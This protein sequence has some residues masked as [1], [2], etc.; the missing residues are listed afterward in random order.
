MIHNM[1]VRRK[2]KG[3][4]GDADGDDDPDQPE[5]RCHGFIRSL[6]YMV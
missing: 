1:R 2:R 5:V 6:I 3:S 4:D